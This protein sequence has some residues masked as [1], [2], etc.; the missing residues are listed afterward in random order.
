M[1]S[2]EEPGLQFIDNICSVLRLYRASKDENEFYKII[3]EMV[4][5]V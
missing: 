4:R 3:E 1:D 5:E 2:Q